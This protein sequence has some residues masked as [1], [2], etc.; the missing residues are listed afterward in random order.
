MEQE[1]NIT[2]GDEVQIFDV[3]EAMKWRDLISG[4]V[5]MAKSSGSYIAVFQ[6]RPRGGE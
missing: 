3:A 5:D 4:R 1:F 2:Q 6:T